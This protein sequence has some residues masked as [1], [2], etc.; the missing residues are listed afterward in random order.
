MR[1]LPHVPIEPADDRELLGRLA[2]GDGSALT[3]L[4]AR[5]GQRLVNFLHHAGPDPSW[6]EDLLQELL[7]RIQ[8]H[9]DRYDPRYPAIVWMLR[10]ARNLA[11]DLCRRER[12]RSRAKDRLAERLEGRDATGPDPFGAAADREF[13]EALHA[14]LQELGEEIRTAFVLREIEGMNYTEIA[15]IL[16]TNEKTVSSRLSRARARLRDRLRDHMDSEATEE[17]S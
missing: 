14:A 1:P 6:A 15:Q 17:G 9:A 3:Q 2:R 13:E 10:I 16:G 12:S 5:H 11:T 4:T 7:V 8:L